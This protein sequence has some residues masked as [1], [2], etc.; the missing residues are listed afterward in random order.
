MA[1]V[2]S[3]YFSKYLQKVSLVEWKVLQL[4]PN[5]DFSVILCGHLNKKKTWLAFVLFYIIK[6]D[7]FMTRWKII[8]PLYKPIL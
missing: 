1:H 5:C 8:T 6:Y 7:Y 3:T 4:P 2:K